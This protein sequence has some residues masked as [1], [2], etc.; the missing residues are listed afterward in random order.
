[1][2]KSLRSLDRFADGT[3]SIV[4]CLRPKASGWQEMRID[5]SNPILSSGRPA[6]LYIHPRSRIQV[7]SSVERISDALCDGPEYHLSISRNTPAGPARVD[8]NDARWVID[9]FKFDGAREDNHVP[10]G[11]V[12][13]FWRPVAG[14]WVGQRCRCEDEEAAIVE[15]RG[16]YVWRGVPK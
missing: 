3:L 13:N 11:R 6:R 4:G 1:M 16:D 8:S 2:S 7:I 5:P 14:D 15:D 9:C 12:R 10:N